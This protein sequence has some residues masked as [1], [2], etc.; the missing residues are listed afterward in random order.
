M[1]RVL[2]SLM[3]RVT[4]VLVGGM[5]LAQPLSAQG[6][7]PPEVRTMIDGIVSMLTVKG[8]STLRSFAE[9]HLNPDYRESFSD[10]ELLDHL[11]GLRAAAADADGSVSARGM[12]GDI[13]VTLDRAG[14]VR[15]RVE[16]NDAFLITKLEAEPEGA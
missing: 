14:K 8:D 11:R 1:P 2:R 3:A 9:R 10:A 4:P 13:V 5:L 7:P 6:G 15:I 12:P 16:F